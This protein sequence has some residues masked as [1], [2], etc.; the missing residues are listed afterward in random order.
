M[1]RVRAL[2]LVALAFL[3]AGAPAAHAYLDPGTA[4]VLFQAAIA[5]VLA[6]LFY[7]KEIWRRVKAFFTGEERRSAPDVSDRNP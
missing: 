5:G 2:R 4:S 6:A 3:I 1:S 7:V